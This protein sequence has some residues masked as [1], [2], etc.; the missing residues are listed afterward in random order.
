MSQTGFT[1][2]D[3]GKLAD[4]KFEVD[5]MDAVV[6]DKSRPWLETCQKN[7]NNWCMRLPAEQN[8]QISKDA[9]VIGK[10]TVNEVRVELAKV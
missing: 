8:R 7:I 1:V 10:Y 4:R 6:D 9:K 3:Y 5:G 2:K